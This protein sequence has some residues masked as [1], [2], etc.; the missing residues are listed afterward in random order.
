M[1]YCSSSDNCNTN[2]MRISKFLTFLKDAQLLG[3]QERTSN[4]NNCYIKKE[5]KFPLL[6]LS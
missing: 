1:W 6:M 5:T 2:K 4:M 3:Q